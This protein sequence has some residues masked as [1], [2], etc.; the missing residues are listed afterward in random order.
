MNI[1]Q[2]YCL[3]TFSEATLKNASVGGLGT[4]LDA[5]VVFMYFTP[6]HCFMGAIVCK[7]TA[8][9]HVD[10]DYDWNEQ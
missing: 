5:L 9:Y 4:A 10:Y 2:R 7:T 8:A 6:S 3:L 1:T